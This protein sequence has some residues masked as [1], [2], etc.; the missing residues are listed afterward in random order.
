MSVSAIDAMAQQLVT[1]QHKFRRRL[2]KSLNPDQKL[3]D[4]VC[5]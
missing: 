5:E 4:E 1:K 3:V 2:F